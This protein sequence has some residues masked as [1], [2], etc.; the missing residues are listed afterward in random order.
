MKKSNTITFTPKAEYVAE[1]NKDRSKAFDIKS[2]S[3]VVEV[4]NDMAVYENDFTVNH[5]DNKYY[6][7]YC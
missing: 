5:N 4:Q 1:W 6:I 2:P 3:V 7:K